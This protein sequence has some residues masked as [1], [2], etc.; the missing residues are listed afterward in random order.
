MKTHSKGTIKVS[1]RGNFNNVIGFLL[2]REFHHKRVDETRKV[3]VSPKNFPIII[4][5]IY[6]CVSNSFCSAPPL[7]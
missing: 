1:D 5:C 4:V 6:I 7:G 3:V 2:V